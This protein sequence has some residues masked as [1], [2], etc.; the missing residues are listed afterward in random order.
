MQHSA[1][2]KAAFESSF[3]A[4]IDGHHAEVESAV[5]GRILMMRVF[6]YSEASEMDMSS[7]HDVKITKQFSRIL[8][9]RRAPPTSSALRGGKLHASS[10]AEQGGF[11]SR[12]Y[13]VLERSSQL[14]L[15]YEGEQGR[16]LQLA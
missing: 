12:F 14:H 9:Q 8:S 7:H 3:A 10:R 1:H 2:H 4:T 6:E 5:E 13:N 11:S 15:A 16:A